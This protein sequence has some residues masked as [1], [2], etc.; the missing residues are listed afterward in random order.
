[1]FVVGVKDRAPDS[2][3][4]SHKNIR[5]KQLYLNYLRAAEYDIDDMGQATQHYRTRFGIVGI[6]R[7]SPAQ[8]DGHQQVQALD[9][10][11]RHVLRSKAE[12]A[13]NLLKREG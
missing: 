2:P 6:A 11:T 8:D 5:T 4:D 9:F 3:L 13:F 10:P 12:E 7:R 1:M